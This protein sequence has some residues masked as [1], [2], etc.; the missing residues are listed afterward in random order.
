MGGDVNPYVYAGDSPT[1]F[2]DPT[3]L[4]WETG[5]EGPGNVC[6]GCIDFGGGDNPPDPAVI[7]R[8]L[9]QSKDAAQAVSDE[10]NTP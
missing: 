5:L 7:Q 2:S 9:D 1:N 10:G 4:D 6:S 8:Y 3:G